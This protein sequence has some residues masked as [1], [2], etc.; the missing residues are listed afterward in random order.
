LDAKTVRQEDI[1]ISVFMH[2]TTEN[3]KLDI[4]SLNL[5]GAANFDFCIEALCTPF[6]CLLIKNK[7]IQVAKNKSEHL[8]DLKLADSGSNDDIEL[9]IGG[10]FYWSLVTGDIK[11]G[12]I[13]EP[14]GVEIKA[15]G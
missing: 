5:K 12:E 4:V 11:R 3:S 14:V 8:K 2:K 6:I 15:F 7:P 13:A 10:D 1:S 9:L